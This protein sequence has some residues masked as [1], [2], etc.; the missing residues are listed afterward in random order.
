MNNEQLKGVFGDKFGAINA[1]FSGLA[2]AGIILTLLLQRKDLAATRSAMGYERFDNT[3]FQLLKL[4]ID[5]TSKLYVG[6]REGR[7]T[8]AVLNEKLKAADPDFFPFGA[9]QKLHAEE[10]RRIIDERAV[11]KLTYPRLEDADVS[12]LVGALSQGIGAFNNYLD[13]SLEMHTR[14]IIAAYR[15]A[16][17]N[18]IDEFSHYFRNLYHILKFIDESHLIEDLDRNRYS[19]FLRAQLSEVELI[20]IFYNCIG[21]INLPGREDMEL[22]YPKMAKLVDKYD[23]LQNMNPLSIIHSTHRTIFENNI[24]RIKNAAQRS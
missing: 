19:K 9:L 4:H 18:L 11:D 7:E 20:A 23:L 14:R 15:K 21:E 1:L 3:F 2:F 24:Q 22:G 5:I 17:T 10:V 13:P 12:N 16:C 8:F 6:G